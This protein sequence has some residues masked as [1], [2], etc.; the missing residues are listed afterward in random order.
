MREFKFRQLVN[1]RWHY[2]GFIDGTFIGPISPDIESNPVDQFIGICDKNK[3]EIYGND[4]LKRENFVMWSRKNG[5]I[6]ETLTAVVEWGGYG[7]YPKRIGKSS[8]YI[9]DMTSYCVVGNV[10][11]HPH[12]LETKP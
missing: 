10:Y 12:L 11:E 9:M 7:Y 3:N 5:E 4:I 1:G 2:F 8:T 6:T